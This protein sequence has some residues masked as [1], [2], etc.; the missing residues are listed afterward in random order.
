MNT[1]NTFGCVIAL[2]MFTAST[3][4]ASQRATAPSREDLL[5]QS[6]FKLVTASN[7]E[8]KRAVSQL[9]AGTCSAVQYNGNVYY[10][11]PTANNDRFYAGKQAQF[12]AYKKALQAQA[13]ATIANTG[14]LP[15]NYKTVALKAVKEGL[16]DP[17]SVKTL[18]L[19]PLAPADMGKLGTTCVFVE[20][21][22]KNGFGGY[23]GNTLVGVYFKNGT[24]VHVLSLFL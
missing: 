22:A 16:K 13:G 17:D 3:A 2:A 14:N 4:D 15:A 24:V 8:Q 20:V 11:Y 18:R 1:I 23:T 12:N 5:V 21:N 19:S 7:Q 6:G 10:V 9:A